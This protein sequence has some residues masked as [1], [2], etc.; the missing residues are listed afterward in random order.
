MNIFTVTPVGPATMPGHLEQCINSVA[1]QTLPEGATLTH[2]LVFDCSLADACFPFGDFP[3]GVRWMSLPANVG[4]IGSTPRTVGVSYA[5]GA[6]ADALTFLD[7]DCAYLPDH[8]GRLLDYS[9]KTE[10]PIACSGRL[11]SDYAGKLTERCQEITPQGSGTPF[12]DTNTFL[13]T[14]AA[15]GI[16]YTFGTLTGRAEHLIGDRILTERALPFLAC[17]YHPTVIYRSLH[18]FHYDA[19]GWPR[20]QGLELKDIAV[21]QTS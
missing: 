9:S 17:H 6:G 8:V 16:S 14:R 13:F 1:A 20:P 5:W 4:D 10:K 18:R 3:P 11:I 12:H 15:L 21:E 2:L 7:A 19:F